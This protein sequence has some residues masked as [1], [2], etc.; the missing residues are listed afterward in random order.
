MNALGFSVTSVIYTIT[1]LPYLPLTY[2]EY[3]SGLV[4][5]LLDQLTC[6]ATRFIIKIN[7]CVSLWYRYQYINMNQDTIAT[8]NLYH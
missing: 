7:M 1:Y 6:S 4:P 2:L 3:H 8:T 5:T